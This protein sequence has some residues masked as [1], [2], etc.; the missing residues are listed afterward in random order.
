MEN[1]KTDQSLKNLGDAL[2]KLQEAI[3]VNPK[4]EIEIDGTI[5]RFEFVFELLWKTLMKNLSNDG[6]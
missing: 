5:Q 6:I 1:N 2:K 4:R 3:N